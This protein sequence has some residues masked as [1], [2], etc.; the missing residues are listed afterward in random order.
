MQAGGGD[1]QSAHRALN[2]LCEAYWYPIYALARREGCSPQ[3]SEDL[4]Q[5]FLRHLL[6][7]R[8]FG[9][10]K[11]E[12]GK[13]RSF[14]VVAFRNYRLTQV[15]RAKAEKRGGKVSF[16]PMD[17]FLAEKKLAAEG[18]GRAPE[19]HFDRA[20]AREALQQ[21]LERT[22]LHYSASGKGDLFQNLF[23]CLQG[24]AKVSYADLSGTLGKSEAALKMETSRLRKAFGETFYSIVAQTVSDPADVENEVRYLFGILARG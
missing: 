4:T 20:W 9:E 15:D 12:F 16:V 8:A 3:D 13:F 17:Q 19:E 21:A 18:S 23:P 6:E 2:Q 7:R 1:S 11:P 24:E 22:R 10:M 5:G 14:L